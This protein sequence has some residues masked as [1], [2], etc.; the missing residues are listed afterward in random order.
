MR[1][2]GHFLNAAVP[3]TRLPFCHSAGSHRTVGPMR[4][5]GHFRKC[6]S[7]FVND[8]PHVWSVLYT[9][10]TTTSMG[11]NSTYKCPPRKHLIIFLV[12]LSPVIRQNLN[13]TRTSH[14]FSRPRI[15]DYAPAETRPA[16]THQTASAETQFGGHMWPAAPSPAS[17]EPPDEADCAKSTP[18]W[19]H[20]GENPA[21]ISPRFAA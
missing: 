9:S 8:N 13:S 7:P 1:S 17:A 18:N 11:T 14:Q 21:A 2:P 16:V 19:P 5:R 3:S 4:S 12:T 6:H 20:P 10:A 15:C